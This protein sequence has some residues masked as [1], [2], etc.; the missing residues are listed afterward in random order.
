MKSLLAVLLL[1]SVSGCSRPVHLHKDV[2]GP[3]ASMG[4]TIVP[5]P[6]PDPTPMPIPRWPLPTPCKEDPWCCL[7]GI[8]RA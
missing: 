2:I 5:V 3:E 1:L 6:I 8:E 7:P 4:V